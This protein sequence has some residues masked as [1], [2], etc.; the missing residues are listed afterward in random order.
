[1]KL[2]IKVK[3][4]NCN[5]ELPTIIEKGEW[6]DLRSSS[7]VTLKAPQSE[8][9]KSHRV[10]DNR[11]YY[12][13]V[14]FDSILIPLGIAMKLPDGFEAIVAPR[15]STYNKFGIIQTNSLGIIDNSYCGNEDE[16]QFPATA[17]RETTI[18]TGDRICQ[19][20]I[21]LSQKATIW[22]RLKW[23]FSSGIKIV[24]VDNLSNN[25]R[26]GIGSTGVK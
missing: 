12:R 2:K 25:N 9:L 16:W 10:G 21:Q 17:L 18:N 13:N 4:L 24:E 5:I 8:T 19:F 23:L 26:S 22:Q 15:S 20:R 11:V 7:T 14:N 1:M 3:R 6:V